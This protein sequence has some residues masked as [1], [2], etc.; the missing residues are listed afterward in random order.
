MSELPL[1]EGVL[2]YI[3]EKNISF[4]MP[5]HKMGR[6]FNSTQIGREFLKN[7]LK[8]DITEVDGVDNLHN[9]T[10]IILEASE[11]LANFYGSKKS[12]FLI[13]GSTSGNMIMIFASLNEGEKVIVERNCHSSILNALIMRKLVPVYI[14]N[15]ISSKLNAPGVL[16]LE[17]FL[18]VIEE[19]KDAKAII[20][21]YPDYYGICSNLEFVI[22]TAK[23]YN[24]KVLVDSAHGAHFGVCS[25][26]PKNAV[27]LGADMVVMS[28]HK[29][30]PS[31]TQTSYLHVNKSSYIDKADFYFNIFLSTSPSYIQL[32]SMDYARFYLEEYG[33]RD[34]EKLIS[35]A[36]NYRNKINSLGNMKILD[37]SYIKN[38][39][40]AMDIDLTRYVINLKKGYS[41]NL[42]LKYLR[43][44][45]IQAE[46]SDSSNVVLIFSPFNEEYEFK[47][48]YEVLKRCPVEKI[49]SEYI[50]TIAYGIPKMEILPF[51]AVFKEKEVIN[52]D[53][54]AGR[55]CGKTI[56][57]Y[58]PGIP[59][60]CPGEKIDSDILETIRYYKYNRSELIGVKDN[61]IEVIK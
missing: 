43:Q 47:K 26:L 31:V 33:K 46:M 53:N 10:G 9:Q 34:Y 13:N 14:E 7:I 40:Y 41:G 5:G 50:P 18:Q 48:L 39:D 12:Y 24:M 56:I 22:K 60:V 58:P 16:N 3:K 23:K 57:P 30:L 52:L 44:N 4:C 2:K 8:F 32:C 11:R 42:L 6:G 17:H 55:I 51:Q 1:L 59:I 28:S 49:K 54:S 36:E 15:T 20:V 61:T 27:E 35:I 38:L 45:K 25:D 37:R 21:T 19:N 29:T